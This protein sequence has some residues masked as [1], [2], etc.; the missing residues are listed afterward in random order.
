LKLLECAEKAGL[1]ELDN[2]AIIRVLQDPK[3][4]ESLREL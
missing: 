4:R 3:L 2:S 1:G